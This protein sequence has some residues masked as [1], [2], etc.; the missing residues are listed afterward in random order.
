ALN[1]LKEYSDLG[2]GEWSKLMDY[3]DSVKFAYIRKKTIE[4]FKEQIGIRGKLRGTRYYYINP[5][6]EMP[7]A[8]DVRIL[9][10]KIVRIHRVEQDTKLEHKVSEIEASRDE[11]IKIINGIGCNFNGKCNLV[12]TERNFCYS[13]SHQV[14]IPIPETV[15]MN[16]T[17]SN[18]QSE[19]K[20]LKQK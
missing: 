3:E 7:I 1:L 2:A 10:G 16:R 5:S 9:E 12:E 11:L 15:R 6:L 13:C 19:L 17:I 18:L 4:R 14:R 20:E 8:K